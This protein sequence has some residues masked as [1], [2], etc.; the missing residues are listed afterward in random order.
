MEDVTRLILADN[1]AGAIN[2][3]EIIRVESPV[4]GVCVIAI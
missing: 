4:D 3:K 2:K 1:L